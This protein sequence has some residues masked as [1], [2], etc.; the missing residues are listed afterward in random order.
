MLL[1]DIRNV[2]RHV[3][4]S[5]DAAAVGDEDSLLATGVIDS[6]AMIELITA[7]ESRF[8]VRLHDDDMT[9]ENFDSVIAIRDLIQQKLDE[10]R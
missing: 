9:P 10:S 4:A 3:G 8:G 1:D 2:I 5:S 6:A 7:L